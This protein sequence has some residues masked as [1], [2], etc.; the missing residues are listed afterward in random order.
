M[1]N[2]HFAPSK[3]KFSTL[4]SRNK[5]NSALCTLVYFPQKI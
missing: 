2:R 5:N 3:H 4:H 1:R